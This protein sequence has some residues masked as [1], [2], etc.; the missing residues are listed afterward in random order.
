MNEVKRYAIISDDWDYV[1]SPSGGFVDRDDYAALEAECER[2]RGEISDLHTTM[3]AA[4][5]EIQEHWAAHC[6]EDGYGPSNLMRRLE[7]GIAAQYGYTAQTLVQLQ[8]EREQLRQQLAERDAEIMEQARCNGMGAERELK[9]MSQRDKL[10][11]ALENVDREHELLR[12]MKNCELLRGR[13]SF[14]IAVMSDT[15]AIEWQALEKDL[16]QLIDARHAALA[17]I[18]P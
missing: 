8:A 15:H 1:E 18:K 14:G 16:Q 12:R 10:A 5:V 3:M 6:D 11:Q 2:L 9:L 13:G 7:N 4:A 17:E